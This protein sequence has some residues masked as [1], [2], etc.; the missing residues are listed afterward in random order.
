MIQRYFIHL[1]YCGAT[2]RGWQR[3]PKINSVQ[4]TLERALAQILGRTTEL[5]G[6]GR[7]DAGVHASQFFAHADLESNLDFNLVDR[8][9]KNLPA[10]IV[11]IEIS[12]V[13]P[14][15]HARYEATARTYEYYIHRKP[16][17]FLNTLS[18]HIELPS[19]DISTMASAARLLLQHEDY[20]GFCK[21]PLSQNNT[22]CKITVA[23][24]YQSIDGERLCLK[25]KSNRFL[26]GMIRILVYEMLL[27]GQGCPIHQRL[28]P[29]LRG[30]LALEEK[31]SAPPQGLYLS[32]VEYPFISA[33]PFIGMFG[34][35]GSEGFWKE[36]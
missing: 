2:Y 27:I 16:N 26:R 20:R 30:S 22:L 14:K 9:N 18:A 34:P 31:Q 6:C 25:I 29:L 5:T 15:A 36:I 4:E 32:N 33:R 19:L 35:L 21:S 28:E 11:V 3:H 10:D 12:P 8:W 7:T 13:H 17:P 24:W 23:Q 1:A